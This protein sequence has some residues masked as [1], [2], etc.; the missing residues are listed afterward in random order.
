MMKRMAACRYALVL[1]FLLSALGACGGTPVPGPREEP[2]SGA[3]G[4]AD[5]GPQSSRAKGELRVLMLA[6]RFADVEPKLSLDNIKQ[7]TVTR[8]NDYVRTQSYGQAWIKPHFMGW[9]PLPD[10]LS[11]YRISPDNF[12][13][14]KG[15][16]R[17]LI[18][19]AMTA[20]EKRAD[21]SQYDDMLVIPGAF[22]LPGKGYGMMCYCANPGMLTGVRGNP[23]Y[24]TLH[25]RGGQTFSGGIS[26]G[27]ENAHLGMFAH[28][29]FHALGG[30]H[31]GKRLVP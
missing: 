24:V 22:T 10:N 14:D 8:L 25:A 7:R 28:D 17:K 26:V 9:I 5:L 3:G 27:T 15:R 11:E 1:F 29:F 12:R 4:K 16:V 23:A 31:D 2:L 30:V 13:V 18:E 19:D 6:V 20:V 21:F